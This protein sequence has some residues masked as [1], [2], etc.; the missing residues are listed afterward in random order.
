[1]TAARD[2]LHAAL[3]AFFERDVQAA[4]S[5]PRGDGEIGVLYNQVYRELISYIMADPRVIEQANHL[6]WAAHNLERTA[7]RVITLC[8][9]VVYAVPGELTEL[10][11]DASG[12]E[13]LH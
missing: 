13:S 3:V 12:I 9:R 8:E 5:I 6:T 11:M 2:M 4:R 1:V 7:D 10:G